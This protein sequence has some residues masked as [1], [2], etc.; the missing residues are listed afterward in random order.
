M[1]QKQVLSYSGF[2]VRDTSAP[3]PVPELNLT[4]KLWNNYKRRWYVIFWGYPSLFLHLALALLGE[5]SKIRPT[6][7]TN[8]RSPLI[9]GMV[10]FFVNQIPTIFGYWIW[11]R[12]F[13]RRVRNQKFG[14]EPKKFWNQISVKRWPKPNFKTKNPYAKPKI[15]LAPSAPFIRDFL[16]KYTKIDFGT[17]M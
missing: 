5:Q 17:Q 14:T 10:F 6:L 9:I 16:H 1:P 15:C 4:K 13:F 7:V 3:I 12:P 2:N 11:F 8:S